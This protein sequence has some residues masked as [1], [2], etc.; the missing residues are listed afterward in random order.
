VNLRAAAA[1]LDV[2]YQTAYGWVR[3]GILPA[4][5]LGGAYEIEPEA[6]AALLAQRN[7]PRPPAPPPV[8]VRDWD[9]QAERLYLL[10]RAGDELGARARLERLESIDTVTICDCLLSPALRRIGEAWAAGEISVAEEHRAAAI[11][12]RLLAARAGHRPGRPRGVAVVA[13]PPREGHG[14]PSVMAAAALRD[15]CWRVNHLGV[16]VPPDD[17]VTLALAVRADLA[18]LPVTLPTAAAAGERLAIRLRGEGVPTLV[19]RPGAALQELVETARTV[20]G[21]R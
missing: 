17:L 13:A 16:G 5:M 14:L 6:V 12:E 15:D 8:H 10:L 2:H 19:G 1:A 4:R 20:T 21:H 9:A 3:D 11:C 7:A 18:V